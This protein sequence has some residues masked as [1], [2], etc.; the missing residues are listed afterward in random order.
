MP[1]PTAPRAR[2]T[3]PRYE[4][5]SQSFHSWLH[6]RREALTALRL[7]GGFVVDH[8]DMSVLDLRRPRT[9]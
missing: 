7:L 9:R 8:Q 4:L 3:A 1:R 2:Y 6:T 5:I